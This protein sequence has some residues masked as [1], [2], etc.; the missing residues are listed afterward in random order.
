MLENIALALI[1]IRARCQRRRPGFRRFALT[2]RPRVGVA[3]R[4]CV[5]MFMYVCVLITRTQ[6]TQH[7]AHSYM[8]CF[9]K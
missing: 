5:C 7:R 8:E 3:R 2:S 9:I 4:V 6:V 1:S